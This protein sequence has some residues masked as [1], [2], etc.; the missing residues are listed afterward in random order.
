MPEIA[1]LGSVLLVHAEMPGP[2]ESAAATLDGRDPRRY[3]T[4]LRSRPRESE[5]EA[6]ALMV[7]LCRETGCRVHIVHHSSSDALPMLREAKAAG[8]PIPV[9]TCPPYLRCAA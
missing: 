4:F 6:I 1:R 3:E 8:L 5:N 9:E 7:G 2:I